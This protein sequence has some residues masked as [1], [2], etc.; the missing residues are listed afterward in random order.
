MRLKSILIATALSVFTWG[1]AFGAA[2]EDIIYRGDTASDEVIFHG[3]KHLKRGIKCDE[4]HNKEMF[5]HKKKGATIIT[6]KAIKQGKLCGKCH[7]GTR[8]FGIDHHCDRCHP[9]KGP[10]TLIYD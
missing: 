10:D 3:D 8:A 5:P 7:N 1:L 9:K 4:C 6:M 2:M